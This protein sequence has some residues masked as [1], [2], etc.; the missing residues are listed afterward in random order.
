MTILFQG[1]S[2]TDCLRAE[3]SPMGRG[4][5][6]LASALLTA[7]Y[8]ELRLTMIN[9]GVSGNKTCDL[10]K[11][12]KKDCLDLE[13]DLLSV[14][15]G[16]NNTWRRYD[17]NDYTPPEQFYRE[18]HSLLTEARDRLDCQLVLG[19]PFVLPVPEDRKQWREDIDPKIHIVRDLAR[20]FDAILIPYDGIFAAA[21]TRV[22]PAYWAE[23]GV[24]PTDAGHAL[25]AES[26]IAAVTGEQPPPRR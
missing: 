4:Y 8:P 16:V 14:L 24:H 2:I 12:W 25:M 26:W 21:S 5:A 9:R 22:D 13:P 23:D 15:I 1:D 11:R 20:E 7:R 17:S 10:V 6:Y 19:E 18:Y 3:M